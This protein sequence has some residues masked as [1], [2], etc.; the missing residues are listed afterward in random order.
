MLILVIIMRILITG[1]TSGIAY[2]LGCSLAKR[3]HMVYFTTHTD[4]ELK[5]LKNKL[6]EDKVDA[7]CFKMDI[8]TDDIEKVD[9]IEIDCLVN[10]AGIGIGGSLL[11]M[12][13]EH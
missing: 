12:D 11:T 5:Q 4:E 8:T 7:L 2:Q 10:H 6:K 9:K 13:V 3:N 1:A